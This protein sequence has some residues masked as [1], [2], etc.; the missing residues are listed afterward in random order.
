M[1]E[2]EIEA[3]FASVETALPSLDDGPQFEISALLVFGP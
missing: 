3:G 1:S 2:E